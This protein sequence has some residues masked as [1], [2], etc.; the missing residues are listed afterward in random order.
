MNLEQQLHAA[1]APCAPGPQPLATVMARLSA[2][3]STRGTRRNSSRLVLFGTLVAVAAAASMLAL[4][5]ADT[6]APQVAAAIPVFSQAPIPPAEAMPE[7]LVEPALDSA[8]PQP[9]AE[10]RDQKVPV[11][12]V[13]SFTV[14]MLPLQNNA[15]NSTARLAINKFHLALLDGLRS[16]PGLVLVTEESTGLAP[17]AATDFRLTLRGSELPLDK[18]VVMLRA[19]AVARRLTL[20]IELSGDI[21]PLCAGAGTSGCGD[22]AAMAGLGLELLRKNIF[23][24]DPV[25]PQALRARILDTSLSA[26]D[27]LTALVDITLQNT[28]G[29]GNRVAGTGIALSDPLIVRSLADLGTTSTDPG[30]RAEVWRSVRFLRIGGLIPS[31]TDTLRRDRDDKV[32]MEAAMTLGTD[33][34]EDPQARATLEAAAQ[35]DPRPIVRALARRGLS[36]EA[37]WTEYVVS[38]LKDTSLAPAA[39]IEALFV[40][41]NQRGKLPDLDKLLT[42]DA[43]IEAFADAFSRAQASAGPELPTTV[44]LSRLG[45]VYHPAITGLL[46][47]SLARAT[48]PSVRQSIV[49]QL[50]RRNADE[51]VQ[52]VLRKISVEDADPEL[53]QMATQALSPSPSAAAR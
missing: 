19:E 53:R 5:L 39:R 21:A 1:L 35:E 13:R 26:S 25:V 2:A 42:D 38:S 36:G 24:G 51:R 43:A 31:L 33:F 3:R 11:V 28:I 46:L 37:A 30:V 32:R 29:N 49:G 8:K 20:P 22:P 14:R 34:A 18:F 17:D 47:D 50:I 23:P 52:A 41:M 10:Q 6:P 40:T 44:L 15:T 12:E 7:A 9:A 27:R 16:V 45:S 48:Q 4:Q